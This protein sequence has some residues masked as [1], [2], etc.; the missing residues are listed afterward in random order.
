MVLL[1][2]AAAAGAAAM[3]QRTDVPSTRTMN[4]RISEVVRDF[5]GQIGVAARNLGTGEEL[6]VNADTRFP[7]ASTIKTAVMLE[8]YRQAAESGLSFDTPIALR[9]EDKV[10]GSG[11][12]RD[13]QPGL[14]V[15]IADLIRLMI[16]LSDNTAT[17]MLIGRL[18]TARS[19]ERSTCT[20]S[21]TRGCSGPRSATGTPTY[22]PSSSGSSASG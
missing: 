18:G 14:P 16:V 6:D 8:A 20:V 19:T 4:A 15:T 21:P 7:T 9:E 12:L 13:L 22:C 3:P 10:G 11:V 2:A 5:K 17:N 1:L